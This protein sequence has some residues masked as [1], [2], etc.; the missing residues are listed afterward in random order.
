MEGAVIMYLFQAAFLLC[1]LMYHYPL[2]Q[3]SLLF[4]ILNHLMK[5]QKAKTFSFL[6]KAHNWLK[7]LFTQSFFKTLSLDFYKIHHSV[8]NFVQM[9]LQD[10]T[11]KTLKQYLKDL[12][13]SSISLRF[14]LLQKRLNLVLLLS[15]SSCLTLS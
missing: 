14:I 10:W 3:T 2:S 5:T 7:V 15:V 11:Q 9:N 4:F 13:P 8:K 1:L 12:L 6:I